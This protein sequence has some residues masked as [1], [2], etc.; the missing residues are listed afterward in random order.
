MAVLALISAASVWR[1]VGADPSQPATGPGAAA[2]PSMVEQPTGRLVYVGQDGRLW[3][4][5]LVTGRTSRGVRLPGVV[6][7]L[8]DASGAGQGWIGVQTRGRSGSVSASVLEGPSDP[9]LRLLGAGDVAA[10]GP[11]GV[12]VALAR[13]GRTDADCPRAEIEVVSVGTGSGAPG[14]APRSLCGPVPSLGRSSAATYVTGTTP[15]GFGLH[16]TGT[17]GIPHLLFGD[18]R[19]VSSSP[20]SAFLLEPETGAPRT[21]LL[22]RGTGGPVRFEEDGEPLV[23]SRV[24]AWSGDALHA[25]VWGSVGSRAG[26]FLLEAGPG[27]GPREP[28]FVTGIVGVQGSFAPD[29]SL[30]LNT[31]DGMFRFVGGELRQV[32]L[33][34]GASAPTGPIL[35]SP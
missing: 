8:V 18:V 31:G 12:S 33:P 19:L 15:D 17:V 34:A 7:A 28:M 11:S 26:V 32:P 35:W 27:R 16:E 9:S 14:L 3:T 21:L 13:N 29:G 20:V 30:F 6:T 1:I 24:L 2:E 25:A 10:W 22:W 5:D 23:V 4:W